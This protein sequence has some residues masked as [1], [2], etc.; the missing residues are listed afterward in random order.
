MGLTYIVDGLIFIMI[1]HHHYL[2]FVNSTELYSRVYKLYDCGAN[3][4]LASLQYNTVLQQ[5]Q[6]FRRYVCDHARRE[7]L[8]G[9]I[10]RTRGRNVE[11]VVEGFATQLQV[12][13]DWL[14]SC[15]DQGMFREFLHERSRPTRIVWNNY[16]QFKILNDAMP[17]YHQ[18]AQPDGIT[19][20]EWSENQFEILSTHS[21][22][23]YRG[24]SSRDSSNTRSSGSKSS[25]GG[26]GFLRKGEGNTSSS[27]SCLQAAGA[28]SLD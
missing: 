9:Y 19:R 13:E 7:N 5:S 2:L 25:A 15:A 11:L 22:N 3:T 10:Q 18:E 8:T 28:R 21:S 17:P 6:G 4:D 26:R 16:N 20:G 14:R 24:G 27:L 1:N 23:L 12:F